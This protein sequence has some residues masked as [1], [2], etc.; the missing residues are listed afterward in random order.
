MTKRSVVKAQHS[1]TR[2]SWGSRGGKTKEYSS[3]FKA[4]GA[5]DKNYSWVLGVVLIVII[6]VALVI[7]L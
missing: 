6:V 1:K 4:N 5:G 7:I 2:G 3:T